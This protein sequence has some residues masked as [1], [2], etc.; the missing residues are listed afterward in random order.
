MTYHY[1]VHDLLLNTGFTTGDGYIPIDYKTYKEC[2]CLYAFNLSSVYNFEKSYVD[3]TKE[4]FINIHIKFSSD[5][6]QALK[7]IV[8]AL[9]DN[10]ILVDGE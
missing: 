2:F 1:T 4:G 5:T 7:V 8:Y 6:T 10:T 9:F 3:L